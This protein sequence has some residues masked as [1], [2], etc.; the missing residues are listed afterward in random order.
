MPVKF[1]S[2][3]LFVPFGKCKELICLFHFDCKIEFFDEN[4][5]WK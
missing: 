5:G 3:F 1:M 4:E 2:K